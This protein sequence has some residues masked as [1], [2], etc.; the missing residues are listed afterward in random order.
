MTQV[1]LVEHR[2]GHGLLVTVELDPAGDPQLPQLERPLRGDES[3]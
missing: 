3:R 2:G 1:A